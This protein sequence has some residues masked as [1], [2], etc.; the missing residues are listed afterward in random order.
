MH[1]NQD[2]DLI[3]PCFSTWGPRGQK[4][5]VWYINPPFH[6][7]SAN[8]TE[9]NAWFMDKINRTLDAFSHLARVWKIGVQSSPLEQESEFLWQRYENSTSYEKF[10]K[11]TLS[12]ISNFEKPIYQVDIVFDLFVSVH[13]NEERG[14]PTQGWVRGLGDFRCRGHLEEEEASC[15]FN[16][17]QSLFQ[18]FVDEYGD[19]DNQQLHS[20]NQPLLYEALRNWEQSIGKITEFE[21]PTG[22]YKYGFSSNPLDYGY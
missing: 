20:L 9:V 4:S 16:L 18:A 19:G 2:L 13:T 14:D 7:K 10:L 15:A 11:Q 17:F 12:Q 8:T 6:L 3:V 21:G 22:C 1:P 5:A